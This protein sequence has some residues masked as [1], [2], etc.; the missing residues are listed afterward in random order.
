MKKPLFLLLVSVF[1]LIVLASF[2][3]LYEVQFMS[4]KA[5][6]SRNSFSVDNSYL[7][8]TPLKARANGQEKIRITIFI[9]NDQGLGVMGKKVFV[10]QDPNLT[11]DTIQGLT[12]AYGKA[13]FDVAGTKTGEYYL[14]VTAD[15]SPL[16]QKA[17]LSFY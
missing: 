16:K 17:H 12:D 15:G 13:Y 4:G 14:E 2:F 3:W 8:V 7:F 11:V 6:I 5:A 10:A 1:V 9:L